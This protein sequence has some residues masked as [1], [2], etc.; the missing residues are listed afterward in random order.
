MEE[1]ITRIAQAIVD[2]P[3][4]VNVK[5]IEGDRNIIFELRVAKEDMG[6]IIGKRGQNIDAIR[7]IL[8]GVSAKQKKRCVLE[9]IEEARSEVSPRL[10]DERPQPQDWQQKSTEKQTGIVTMFDGRK[11]YGFI[12]MDDGGEIF[13]HHSSVIEPGL[14]PLTEG[15]RVTFDVIQG[16]KGLKAINVTKTNS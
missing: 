11:G 3:D 8:T 15:D 12:T 2:N 10:T 13:V 9:L 4:Q 5:K 14:L 1:L 16:D 7:S 6:K